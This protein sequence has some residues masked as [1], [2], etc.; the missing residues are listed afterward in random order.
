[1][2]IFD[3]AISY[4]W[5]Y[6][7][8][9]IELIEKKFQKSGFKTFII[10]KQNLNEVA[11]LL[12]NKEIYFK[13]YL[14]RASDEDPEFE[15]ITKLLTRKRSYIINPHK[16]T[17]KVT[18]K[19]Y[20]HKK[21]LRKKF[22]LPQTLI[23]ESYDKCQELFLTESKI[24]E[25][26]IPFVIKPALFSGG[27]Q[28]VIKDGIS[29]EQIQNQR[30]SSHTEKFL[31]QEKIHPIRIDHKRAWF[32]IF[33][34]FGK[35]IPTWWDD[36]THIYHP[37]TKDQITKYKLHQLIKI[38]TKL[39]RIAAIDYFSTEIALTKNHKFVL[40]DYINDQCDMRLQSLHP[41]GVPDIV[42]NQFIDQLKRK[43]A[44]L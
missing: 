4:T 5:N 18:D 32:R 24:E 41:D 34:A 39:S 7:I 3:L 31:V 43:V 35:V 33:W 36:H 44:S 15:I 23:L 40:I 30:I 38:T 11:N 37:L 26:K 9:F 6:D 28:G 27:G 25:L 2:L 13:A 16:K 19:S 1:M 29:I 20:F 17:K 22:N 42:V 8:E 14:D 21:L 12:R 10:Y